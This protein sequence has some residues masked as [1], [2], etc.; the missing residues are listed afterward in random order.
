[1]PAAPERS[2]INCVL[3]DTAAQL[4]R[5]LGTL[6]TEYQRAGVRAW[7][8]W[9]PHGEPAATEPLAR[10][11]H[12]FDGRPAA[13]ALEL[14]SFTASPE[15]EL[16]L[17]QHPSM[18]VIGRLN[19][20]VYGLP[21]DFERGLDGI[22]PDPFHL[23]VATADGAPVCSL[24]AY[25]HG[26]DCGIYLVATAPA[27]RGRGLATTVL[28]RALND[29]RE[30]GCTTSSLQATAGGR[31]VYE[32]LGYRDLGEIQMWERRRPN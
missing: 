26:G 19:D 13:M 25:D 18:A 15:P 27:A 8:V 11:G 24:V 9:V 7:T 31:P 14:G 12:V 32:R 20:V 3:Y 28:I 5:A 16:A 1:M 21:G 22:P 10:A 17:A 23:Y 4:E 6:A 2:V 30:R 29:A